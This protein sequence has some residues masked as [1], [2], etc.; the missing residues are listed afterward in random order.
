ML[1]FK[2]RRKA[3]ER[4]SAEYLINRHVKWTVTSW[5][6]GKML[7]KKT[8]RMR[9]EH[10]RR[11]NKNTDR[12]EIRSEEKIFHCSSQCTSKFNSFCLVF[13]FVRNSLEFGFCVISNLAWICWFILFNFCLHNFVSWCL[14]VCVSSMVKLFIS[15]YH[16]L[17]LV[18]VYFTFETFPWEKCLD[19]GPSNLYLSILR[20]IYAPSLSL[21]FACIRHKDIHI[22]STVA[23]IHTNGSFFHFISTN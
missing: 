14:C 4:T 19:A 12:M 13:N 18:Y 21:F 8:Y 15:I 23:H 16:L 1:I 10:N 17:L 22:L 20:I 2:V 11:K 5:W 3:N 9:I 6:Y 7:S